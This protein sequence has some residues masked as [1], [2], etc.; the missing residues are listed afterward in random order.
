VFPGLFI[1]GPE[2]AGG[3]R[4]WGEKGVV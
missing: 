1:W 2:D 4:C 3:R